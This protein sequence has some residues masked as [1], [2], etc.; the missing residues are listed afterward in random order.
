MIFTNIPIEN[1]DFL[2]EQGDFNAGISHN[3]QVLASS[4]VDLLENDNNAI[5]LA[6]LESFC[7]NGDFLNISRFLDMLQT[8]E[9]L[10]ILFLAMKRH[11]DYGKP[12]LVPAYY[13]DSDE[14]AYIN[15]IFENCNWDEWKNLELEM[16][17]IENYTRG[18]VAI[19]CIRGL[20]E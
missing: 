9:L 4:S 1:G 6:I 15:I 5:Y 20:L 3:V 12:S 16:D 2:S 7:E 17:Y 19:V 14:V 8:Y 10:Q 11:P 13:E 18:I